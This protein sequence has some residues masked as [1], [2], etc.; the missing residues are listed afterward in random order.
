MLY[1]SSKG[2]G[3]MCEQSLAYNGEIEV[4]NYADISGNIIREQ[5]HGILDI[6]LVD[7]TTSTSKIKKNIIWARN[8]IHFE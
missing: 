3:N 5:M 4:V 7:R 2:K 6:L 1:E 8:S